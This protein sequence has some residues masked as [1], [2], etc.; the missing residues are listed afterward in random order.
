M[1]LDGVPLEGRVLLT[2]FPLVAHADLDLLPLQSLGG[3]EL[4]GAL[5]GYLAGDDV[6]EEHLL[7]PLGILEE[8]LYGPLW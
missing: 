6:V 8:C 1:P 2:E 3:G 5:R 4:G 7:E